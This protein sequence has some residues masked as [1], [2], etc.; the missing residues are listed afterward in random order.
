MWWPFGAI[1]FRFHLMSNYELLTIEES[2][3]ALAQGWGI[4]HVHDLGTAS[5]LVRILPPQARQHVVN[6]AK[7]GHPIPQKALRLI[8]HYKAH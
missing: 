4:H 3:S 8:N 6:L 5:W 2:T 7:A 1:I